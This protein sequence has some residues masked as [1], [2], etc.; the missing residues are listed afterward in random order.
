MSQ[1]NNRIYYAC[2]SVQLAGPSGS[3]NDPAGHANDKYT[4]IQG[5]QSVGINTNFNLEPIY[6]MGQLDLYDNF[7]DIPDVEV[8]LS[9]V[10][11]GMPTIYSLAMGTGTLS[12]VAENRCSVRLTIHNDTAT[13]A[14]GVAIAACKIEPAYLSSVSYNFPSDGN[15]TEDVTIVGNNKIWLDLDTN[16]TLAEGHDTQAS[17]TKNRPFADN[18]NTGAGIVRRAMFKAGTAAGDSILPNRAE[19]SA[20]T[21]DVTSSTKGGVPIHNQIQS[22]S[23]S[24]DLGREEIYS[25]GSRLP[26]TRFVNFPVE[27]TCDIETIAAT[28]DMVGASET[29]TSCS[30]PKALVDKQIK[31]VLCDGSYYDLGSKNKLQSVSYEGADTGGGNATSTFSYLTYSHFTHVP[32][33]DALAGSNVSASQA[34]YGDFVEDT[35]FGRA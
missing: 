17:Q 4:V 7:E 26:Y 34:D 32:A 22:I 28:G 27:V 31:I 29:E 9:K 10:L 14:E 35:D 20:G 13:N 23:I 24:M 21:A 12:E 19:A 18:P 30:N 15:F 8:S 11:D 2:Q 25:L 1:K 6:Q 3:V 5:L 33:N 16:Q